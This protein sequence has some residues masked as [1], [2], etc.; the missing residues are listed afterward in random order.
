MCILQ[1]QNEDSVTKWNNENEA[2]IQAKTIQ[3]KAS[4]HFFNSFFMAK[5]L[6]GGSYTYK[7]VQ[8]WTKKFDPFSKDKIII[9]VN[10]NNTHWRLFCPQQTN[11][12][13]C[14]MFSCVN[15]EFVAED[16]P[17]LGYTQSDIEYF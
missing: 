8:N 7:N 15:A 3:R 11:S 14:G 10:V 9:P 17:L 5:L 13:D 16:I 1:C 2:A 4:S 6:E 12:Y